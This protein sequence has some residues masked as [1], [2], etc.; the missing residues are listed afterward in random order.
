MRTLPQE[1]PDLGRK[2]HVRHGGPEKVAPPR[3]KVTRV[4]S[5]LRLQRGQRVTR[6]TLVLPAGIQPAHGGLEVRCLLHLATGARW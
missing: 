5:D 2:P 4:L 1:G 3:E 6:S